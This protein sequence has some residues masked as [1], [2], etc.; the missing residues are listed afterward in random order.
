M[1]I[2]IY[3]NDEWRENTLKHYVGE[4]IPYEEYLLLTGANMLKRYQKW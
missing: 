3:T 1:N 2:K 4:Y